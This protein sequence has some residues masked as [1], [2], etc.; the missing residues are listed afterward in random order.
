MN[1]S[2]GPRPDQRLHVKFYKIY[3]KDLICILLKLFQKIEKKENFKTCF[4][5]L[6]LP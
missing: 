3:K 2:P 1:K 4:K 5:K 6:V